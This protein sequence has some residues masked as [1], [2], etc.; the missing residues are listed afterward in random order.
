MD[1]R[2][3]TIQCVT[4]CDNILSLIQGNIQ[5]VIVKENKIITFSRHFRES[6][7]Y[8]PNMNAFGQQFEHQL[9]TRH[10]S[11]RGRYKQ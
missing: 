2:G 10:S 7:I 3:D 4:A 8:S 5:Q 11:G 1:W 9:R 6:F